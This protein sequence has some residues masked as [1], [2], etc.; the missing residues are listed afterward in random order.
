MEEFISICLNGKP[1]SWLE[2]FRKFSV[3]E[4]PGILKHYNENISG[5]KLDL[6]MRNFAIS[7]RFKPKLQ[8][9]QLL[10]DSFTD[11]ATCCTYKAVSSHEI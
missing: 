9:Q 6:L 1:A 7:C 11:H 2:Y 8:S 4:L 10:S 3:K 5:K